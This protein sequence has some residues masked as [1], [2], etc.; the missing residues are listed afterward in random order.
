MPTIDKRSPCR[1]ARRPRYRPY[2]LVNFAYYLAVNLASALDFH[3][4][5]RAARLNKK[6]NLASLSPAW[7]CR[8]AA[9][10]RCGGRNQRSLEIQQRNQFAAV[11]H[12]KILERKAKHRVNSLQDVKSGQ[13][14]R[15][16][17]DDLLGWLYVLYVEAGI[18]VPETVAHFSSRLA[19]LGID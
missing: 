18:V 19:S 13:F 16:G 9:P 1:N 8:A 4:A 5:H 12:D 15:A 2:L 14:E 17:V 6:V 11:V 3:D 10:V 7:T